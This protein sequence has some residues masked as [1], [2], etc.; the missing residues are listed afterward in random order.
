M[1]AT[2][3]LQLIVSFRHFARGLFHVKHAF[4]VF[5]V[6]QPSHFETPFSA[7]A[8]FPRPFVSL[9]FFVDRATGPAIIDQKTNSQIFR[10]FHGIGPMMERPEVG[11]VNAHQLPATIF[12]LESRFTVFV[13][14]VPALNDFTS[15]VNVAVFAEFN[16][17][18]SFFHE[19]NACIVLLRAVRTGQS[20]GGHEAC[21]DVFLSGCFGVH[22]P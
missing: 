4:F 3:T 21:H 10:Q 22:S 15:V 17:S 5:N 13:D 20:F 2:D 19:D 12:V 6:F 18:I 14:S 7:V 9:L 8:G 16:T 11:A 1:A